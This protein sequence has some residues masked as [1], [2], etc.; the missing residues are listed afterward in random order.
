MWILQ[1]FIPHIAPSAE[2]LAT[3]PSSA[4]TKKQAVSHTRKAA[5]LSAVLTTWTR[6]FK[7]LSWQ[8]FLNQNPSWPASQEGSLWE[9]EATR[10]SLESQLQRLCYS[11]HLA[12]QW[13]LQMELGQKSLM[14]CGA[15]LPIHTNLALHLWPRHWGTQPS[16]GPE[17]DTQIR[18]TQNYFDNFIFF[19]LSS[20]KMNK[21]L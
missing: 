9:R 6:H 11:S 13:Q 15:A 2:G 20:L 17:R 3:Q 18:N 4:R 1:L 21:T 12:Q 7:S 14:K 8:R 5:T 16:W 19:L 10:S